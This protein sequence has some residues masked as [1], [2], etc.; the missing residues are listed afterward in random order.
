MLARE[1]G[2]VFQCARFLRAATGDEDAG[3]AALEELLS[4]LQADSAARPISE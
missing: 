4:D 3:V 1:R 2:D